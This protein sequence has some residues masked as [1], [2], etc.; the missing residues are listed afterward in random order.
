M[1]IT[2][3][4]LIGSIVIMFAAMSFV[5]LQKLHLKFQYES[6]RFANYQ[7]LHYLLSRDFAMSQRVT[8]GPNSFSLSM[9][10]TKYGDSATV[11]G[12]VEYKFEDQLITRLQDGKM[13][14]FGFGTAN[15]A[16]QTDSTNKV[17]IRSINF[18]IEKRAW[19]FSKD[20]PK[21]IILS[22]QLNNE[23][24]WQ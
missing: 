9:L 22:D 17:L 14:T 19:M 21:D 2:V 23:S 5:Q 7:R 20:Y 6:D 24:D 16:V 10:N 13:D 15:Y 12:N 1:E 8:V 11:K 3:G 4:L 18:D